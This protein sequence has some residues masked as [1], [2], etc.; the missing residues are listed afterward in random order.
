MIDKIIETEI[1]YFNLGLFG[2]ETVRHN[3]NLSLTDEICQ[4]RTG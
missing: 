3:V 2:L 4:Y 1:N